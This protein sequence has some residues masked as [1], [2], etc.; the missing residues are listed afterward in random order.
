LQ[1]YPLTLQCHTTRRKKHDG[2]IFI[3]EG[4]K[5]FNLLE[6]GECFSHGAGT[7]VA[8]DEEL[9]SVAQHKQNIEHLFLRREERERRGRGE[10]GQKTY[11]NFCFGIL[12]LNIVANNHLFP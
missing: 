3:L 12:W 7:A 9:S 8:V 6:D 10:G 4:I 11:F 1:E 5:N 2:K